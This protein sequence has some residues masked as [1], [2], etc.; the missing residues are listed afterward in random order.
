MLGNFIT[1]F[2]CFGL[3]YFVD[4]LGW[5]EQGTAF[6]YIHL[7]IKV[8]FILLIVLLFVLSGSLSTSVSDVIETN[9]ISLTI[10]IVTAVIV[11]ITLFATWGAT[12]LFNV[13]FFVAYQ[14]MT[15]GQCL[16]RKR[17]SEEKY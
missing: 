5:A 3:S 12:R 2:I 4:S 11:G 7:G 16:C 14:I 15:F 6:L 17:S 9:V 1:W 10:V 13:D 8:A